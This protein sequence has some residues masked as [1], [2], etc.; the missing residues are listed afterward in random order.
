[1]N[2]LNIFKGKNLMGLDC[3]CEA[4]RVAQSLTSPGDG[5]EDRRTRERCLSSPQRPDLL[6][7]PPSLL[8]IGYEGPFSLE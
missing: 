1:M 4:A 7:G 6:W 3:R 5:L 8:S 2:P